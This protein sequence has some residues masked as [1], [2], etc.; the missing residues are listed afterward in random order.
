[1]KLTTRA[2]QFPKLCLQKPVAQN[3]GD[4]LLP[5]EV[6]RSGGDQRSESR[7]RNNEE[8]KESNGRRARIRGYSSQVM[9]TGL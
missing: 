4:L 3:G 1:M 2:K 8:G 7:R 5:R 6:G 9:S